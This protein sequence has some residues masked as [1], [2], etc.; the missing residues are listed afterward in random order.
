MNHRRT[1]PL[2]VVATRSPRAR[3]SLAAPLAVTVG[4]VLCVGGALAGCSST[5]AKVSSTASSALGAA[6][7]VASQAAS[8]AQSG[9]SQAASAASSAISQA[10]SAANSVSSAGSSAL[11]SAQ[12][13]AS[14]AV[15]GATGGLDATGD[16][17]LGQVST[18]SS[19]RAEVV[20]TVNNHG[21]QAQRY[22]IEV[23]FKNSEG[24][25][26]DTTLVTLGNVQPGATVTATA[27]SGETLSGPVMASVV[28]AQRF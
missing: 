17:T 23:G 2:R 4:A 10:A 9:V 18:N 25:L 1:Q 21:S 19:D 24:N 6:Q 11:A 28:S 20:V 7:S 22:T 16:V 8:A 27:T 26:L 3:R 13:A 14:S 15:A 12:S 5:A